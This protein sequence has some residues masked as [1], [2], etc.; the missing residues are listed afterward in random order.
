MLHVRR[1]L[2]ISAGVKERLYF[3]PDCFTHLGI[4]AKNIHKIRPTIYSCEVVDGAEMCL[5]DVK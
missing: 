3:K 5:S 2:W 1:A 4:Y